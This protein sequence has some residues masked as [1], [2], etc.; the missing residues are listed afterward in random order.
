DEP[1]LDMS[2]LALDFARFTNGVAMRHGEVSR[3]MF[4]GH[5]IHAI[6]N[7]VHARTWTSQPFQD[8]FDRYIPDWRRDGMV[9]RHALSI[10]AEEIAEAHCAAKRNLMSEIDRR[11]RDRMALNPE[12]FTIGFA[13]RA[14]GYKRSTLV[15]S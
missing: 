7:G 11:A 15:L 6:T 10:P 14:T 9:L 12:A 8:L 4:P 1:D 13:R 5:T 2:S 3:A